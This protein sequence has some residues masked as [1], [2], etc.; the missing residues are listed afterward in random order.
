MK[1]RDFVKYVTFGGVSILCGCSKEPAF[2]NNDLMNNNPGLP[3]TKIALHM[4]QNRV[5]GVTT[6]MEL[7]EYPSMEGK[8]VVLKPN[9][10]TADPAPA[11]THNDTLSQIVKEINS[12]SASGICLAER[13]YQS[14]NTVI[15]TKGVDTLAQNLGFE[16]RDL[17]LD[18]YT[19]FN[20]EQLHWQN[21][22]R[23]PQTIANAEY[24]VATCC[25]KTHFIGIITMSLKLGVGI[26][27]A[28]HM[29]ELHNSPII[30]SMIAEINL[31]YK[32]DLIIMDGVDTFING[33]PSS[34]TRVAGNI[35]VA[36]TDRIAVDAVGTA[37]LKDLGSPRVGGK[38]FDLEQM[39]RPE[40]ACR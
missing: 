33:G 34:G 35:F 20:N 2:A 22:F 36:G 21:G 26:L 17:N 5:E 19:V 24:I 40:A 29:Q 16:I 8:S 1:R 27:P 37:I 14:F 32:P 38:I 30:N 39:H 4:T 18:D 11:S 28:L 15:S 23:L 9:F 13:S 7:L 3:P 31:A 10:N 25:L 12:R 6:V